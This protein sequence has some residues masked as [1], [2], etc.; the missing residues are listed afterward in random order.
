MNIF[1]LFVSYINV[2][3]TQIPDYFFIELKHNGDYEK[4]DIDIDK[5]ND[6]VF[7]IAYDTSLF[8]FEKNTTEQNNCSYF[9]E[10]QSQ[11]METCKNYNTNISKDYTCCVLYLTE[12]TQGTDQTEESTGRCIQVNKHELSRYKGISLEKFNK[13]KGNGNK[14]ALV[15]SS[16]YYKMNIINI[17][18]LFFILYIYV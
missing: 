8:L 2:I 5:Y 18:L 9:D 13:E 17:L 15:C 12:N 14:A 10:S 1:F 4:I 3:F 11:S 16:K 6:E 7:S